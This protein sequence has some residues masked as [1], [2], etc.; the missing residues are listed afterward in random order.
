[1]PWS[2]DFCSGS[3]RMC[4]SSWQLLAAVRGV[5]V[6]RAQAEQLVGSP[7]DSGSFRAGVGLCCVEV[8]WARDECVCVSQATTPAG[9]LR[10]QGTHCR[11]FSDSS[12]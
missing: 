1:M 2:G 7:L 3:G 8:A 9:C 12:E 6:T 11:T 10:I 4:S 5:G